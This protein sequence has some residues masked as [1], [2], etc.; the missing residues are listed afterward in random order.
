VGAPYSIRKGR[1][2]QTLKFI[3]KPGCRHVSDIA[4][5]HD[6]LSARKGARMAVGFQA[7]EH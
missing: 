2:V 1:S 5:K 4:A 6:A 3:S 7:T